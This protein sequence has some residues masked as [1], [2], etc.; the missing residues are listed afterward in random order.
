MPMDLQR[1]MDLALTRAI[2]FL[3]RTQR[4]DGS[5]IPLWFGN[6]FASDDENPTYGTARVLRALVEA[7][8]AVAAGLSLRLDRPDSSAHGIDGLLQKGMLWLLSAQN[9]DGSWGGFCGAAASV[10]ETALAVEALAE[11]DPRMTRMDAKE[12]RAWKAA[13]QSGA[14]WLVERVES[15]KWRH[16][17]PIGFYFAR[18][19]YYEKLYPLIFTVGALGKAARMHPS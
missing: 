4:A 2:D 17:S 3:A 7:S 19:W 8:R 1:R 9:A 15:G 6:Q 18:L 5:W 11:V 13:V 10:E 16:P 12:I 14:E